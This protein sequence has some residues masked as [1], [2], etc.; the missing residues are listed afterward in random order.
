[1]SE[2]EAAGVKASLVSVIRMQK[3]CIE[4]ALEVDCAEESCVADFGDEV[5]C[6][7]KGPSIFSGLRIDPSHVNTKANVTIFLGDEQGVGS[8]WSC[9]RFG[10]VG[11]IV[12][13]NTFV[14]QL[15]LVM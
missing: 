3:H 10:Y 9:A 2:S 8:P 11:C 6:T 15:L 12:F 1:M 4:G 13:S 14:Q 7:G 5:F